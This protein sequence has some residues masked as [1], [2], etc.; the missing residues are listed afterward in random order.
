MAEGLGPLGGWAHPCD[1]G[2]DDHVVWDLGD[3]A[4]PVVGI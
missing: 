1:P 3:A 4:Q 2:A